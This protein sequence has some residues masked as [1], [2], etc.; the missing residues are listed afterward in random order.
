LTAQYAGNG[1]FNASASAGVT[2]TVTAA[3][4][5]VTTTVL[6]ISPNPSPT[7]QSVTLTATVA[8]A[9]GTPTG[10]V[11]FLNNGVAFGSAV[12]NGG[13]AS[14]TAQALPP[15]TYS[16]A[17]QY[18]GNSTFNTSASNPISWT[19]VASGVTLA[20]STP[21]L[22]VPSGVA[23]SNPVTLTLT[24]FGGYTGTLQMACQSPTPAAS[25]SFEPQTVNVG[26]NSGP[27]NVTMVV[28]TAPTVASVAPHDQ[29]SL[30]G[31]SLVFSAS[32]FWI[33]G[34]LAAALVGAKRKLLPRSAHLLLMLLLCGIFGVI[35]GCGAGNI[36]SVAVSPS[37]TALKIMVTGTGNVSQ[38]TVLSI[39]SK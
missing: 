37:T 23:S 2:V 15:G 34:I 38:T 21:S 19:I 36:D 5:P 11:S 1:N 16:I 3:S 31:Q 32:I 20:L 13:V 28:Q 39:T 35:T 9:S 29:H 25:C 18:A 14:Y 24:P 30:P 8:S 22:V 10:T 17:A 33:P 4:L 26:Q 27:T 12:L 7:G 6:Q